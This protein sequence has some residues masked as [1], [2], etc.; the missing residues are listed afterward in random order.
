V[1]DLE[2]T[3]DNTPLKCTW[4][5]GPTSDDLF[6]TGANE[7]MGFFQRAI[8]KK[9]GAGVVQFGPNHDQNHR[10]RLRSPRNPATHVPDRGYL[11]P[12]GDTFELLRRAGVTRS[13]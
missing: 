4:R 6:P 11:S 1:I 13:L 12:C 5:R 8:Q 7:E 3:C 9:T 10:F 2:R